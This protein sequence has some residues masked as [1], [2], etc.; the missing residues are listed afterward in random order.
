MSANLVQP[1]TP[2]WHHRA[3]TLV[4]SGPPL[5]IAFIADT[6]EAGIGGGVIAARHLIEELRQRHEVTVVG[7]DAG[8]DERFATFPL[9]FRAVR[10]IGFV[11]ARPDRL[12][13][14]RILAS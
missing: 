6:L 12:A 5:R 8:A 10:D 3:R 7:A 2:E 9:P 4:A 11:L 14:R 13:L 1:I